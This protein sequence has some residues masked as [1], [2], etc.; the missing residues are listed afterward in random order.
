M[1]VVLPFGEFTPDQPPLNNPGI[2]VARNCVPLTKQS[3]GPLPSLAPFTGNR[4]INPIPPVPDEPF[5]LYSFID[6]TS[7]EHI[8]TGSTSQLYHFKTGDSQFKNVS[9]VVTHYTLTQADIAD[10]GQSYVAGDVVTVSWPTSFV[11]AQITIDSVNPI[12]YHA[13][14]ATVPSGGTLYAVGDVLTLVGGTFVT[15]SEITVDNVDGSGV[16]IDAHFSNAGDDDYSI[17][18]TNP[19]SVTGG[20]GSGATFDVEFVL[21]ATSASVVTS[22]VSRGGDYTN[23]PN[24][25]A[26]VAGGA[27][28]GLS[29]NLTMIATTTE[30]VTYHATSYNPFTMVG[31]GNSIIATTGDDPPQVMNIDND[32]QFS[33]LNTNRAPFAKYACVCRNFLVFAHLTECFDGTP[34]PQR[35]HWSA[36]GDA[37]TWPDLGSAEAAQ[38]QSDAQDLR[39]DLGHIRGIASNLQAADMAIFLDQGVYTARY[40]GSPAIFDFQI[41]QGAVGCQVPRSIIINRGIA[42][43]L[44]LDGWYAFDG[45]IPAQIGSE[46]I[47][48][49]FFNDPVDGLDP[50]YA[51][52]TQGCADPT[53]NNVYWAYCGPDSNGIPNRLLIFNFNIA[54]WSYARIDIAWLGRA[55]ST[56]WS[57]DQLGQFSSSLDTLTPGLDDPYWSGGKPYLLAFNADNQV[58]TFSGPNLEATIETQEGQPTPSKRSRI[59][60]VRPLIDGSPS[61]VA[62]GSR[63]RQEDAVTYTTDVTTNVWGEAPHR[64]DARYVRGRITIPEAAVWSHA[65][66]VDLSFGPSTYR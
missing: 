50:N 20:T 44:G 66:G 57:V 9:G 64:T 51:Y 37:G 13:S 2:T 28:T 47:D 36:I 14:S 42:Y 29:F 31:F 21:D 59:T 60:S 17:I 32:S 11:T 26:Q 43:Y 63:N 54:R 41:A 23:I 8:F 3:Y 16:I 65:E 56:G 12:V 35:L 49:W 39:S 53:G 38:L 58:C 46:K 52:L 18:P 24:D 5:G 62:L 19:I 27:G 61:A 55:L 25:P 48:N 7:S 45:T 22:H 30:A 6:R 10:A 15:A 40:V 1:S 4:S 33:D 34:Y